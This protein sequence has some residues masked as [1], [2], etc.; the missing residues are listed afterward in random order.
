MKEKNLLIVF[1]ITGFLFLGCGTTAQVTQPTSTPELILPTV[2]ASTNTPNPTDTSIP[3]YYGTIGGESANIRSG[4]GTN[5]DVINSF[6]NGTKLQVVGRNDDSSW[7]VINLPAGG[8]G[9][10]RVDL[11]LFSFPADLLKIYTT[12]ATPTAKPYIPPEATSCSAETVNV[13]IINDTGGSVSLTLRGPCTY[14]F[15]IGTGNTTISILPGS[16]SYSAYG[17]G[18]ATL[19]G[20]KSLGSGDEWTWYCQ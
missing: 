10:I 4:P 1:I 7:L 6:A 13:T 18:G 9:W 14:T 2:P 12:P 3:E 8:I 11:I 17:C 5:F 20:S 19:T 15:F 16:Y